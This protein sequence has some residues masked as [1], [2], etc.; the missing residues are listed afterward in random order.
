MGKFQTVPSLA[1]YVTGT[2]MSNWHLRSGDP[3][4]D[5]FTSPGDPIFWLHH[6]MMDRM[7]ATWCVRYPRLFHVEIRAHNV[8]R[9]AL[10]PASRQSELDDSLYGHITWT[11]DPPARLSL[12]SDVLD[13]GYIGPSTTIGDVM[14]TTSGPFCYFYQPG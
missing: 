1:P 13:M 11:N 3:G 4:G 2:L 14:D 5:L 7:W 9:Q 8:S 12:P 6:S 10:G